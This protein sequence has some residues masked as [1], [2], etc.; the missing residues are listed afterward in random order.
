MKKII[1]LGLFLAGCTDTNIASLS[2][3]GK[4]AH[5]ICYSAD[6]IILD[7]VST[8]RIQSVDHSDGWEFEDS[9]DGKF[10]RVS[11]PCVI[12]N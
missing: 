11:G 6:E 1:I 10:V 8:G 7:T 3:Y 12:R 5:I 9:K 2:A 4:K